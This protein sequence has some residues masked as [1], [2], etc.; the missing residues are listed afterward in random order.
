MIDRNDRY[1]LKKSRQKFLGRSKR[2]FLAR[3]VNRLNEQTQRKKTTRKRNQNG[4]EKKMSKKSSIQFDVFKSTY[5]VERTFANEMGWFQTGANEERQAFP[6]PSFT[7]SN[8]NNRDSPLPHTP[9]LLG[10]IFMRARAL[11]HAS[12]YIRFIYRRV[13]T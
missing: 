8:G 9:R 1:S 3:E 4:G 10:D 11:R 5:R 12:V 13:I 7:I 2:R 6:R